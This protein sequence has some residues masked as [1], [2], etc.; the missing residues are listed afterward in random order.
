MEYPETGT[1]EVGGQW[2]RG[3]P[4]PDPHGV[5][6]GGC[7]AVSKSTRNGLELVEYQLVGI[8]YSWHGGERWLR[9]I[10]IREWYQLVTSI[11]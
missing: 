4:F 1:R 6:G 11:L 5:S 2:V 8:Q 9:A 7:F 10:P 3:V